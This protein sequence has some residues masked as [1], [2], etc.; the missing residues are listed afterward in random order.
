MPFPRIQRPTAPP[1]RD[2][3][4]LR[5]ADA[6]VDESA[7]SLPRPESDGTIFA[8]VCLAVTAV[9]LSGRVPTQI[10]TTG[11]VGV[12]I[13]LAGSAVFDFRRGFRNLLR[14]D[15]L[16]LA[17][18]Y[19]LTLFEFLFPQAEF[20]FLTGPNA[21][22]GA[23]MACLWGFAG[24]LVGR[25]LVSRRPP[26]FVENFTRPVP[27]RWM[28]V[29]FWLCFALGFLHMLI[30]V[31]FDV[32]EMIEYFLA[33]R[34]AQPW[35]RG[36]F[37]DWK[38]LLVELG[39]FLYL[40]PPIAGVILARREGYSHLQLALVGSGFLFTLFYG[41]T[42]GTRNIFLSYLVT[43]LSGYAFALNRRKTRELLIISAVVTVLT[44][45]STI[46]MLEF[47]GLGM[48]AW[49]DGERGAAEVQPTST[50]RVDLNLWTIC[51]L[52]DLFP[53][54][55]AYLGWEVPYLALI[56]PIPRAL[57]P[58]KPEGMSKTIEAAMGAEGWT[59]AASFIGEAYM[60]GG[61]IAVVLCGL[62]FGAIISWWNC[63]GSPRNSELGIL[64]YA[65][66]FL[67]AVISMRS[68]FVFTTAI[69]PTVAAVVIGGLVAKKL[70]TQA[71]R[72]LPQL[73]APRARPVPRPVRG[74]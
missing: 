69:L 8:L 58:G 44:I 29:I 17:S 57:W 39:L 41:F 40:V 74:P 18:L 27:A 9:L 36:K 35:Q 49:L 21:T 2:P 11:A 16:A 38:A 48:R 60:A 7:D 62:A 65:S 68:L 64:I 42:T 33:P 51:R 24:L 26:A 15:L 34:F 37:G 5:K 20:N 71:R 12:G 23:V 31:K 54:Q 1:R 30:A 67:A 52:V 55:Q 66:G 45:A 32:A 73:L 43:F 28:V 14:A 6:G 3:P 56:R 4:G 53:R 47:R 25:H 61:T 63:F 50:L 22:K 70:A 13:A 19:F 72:I 10:A 46:L 59:V